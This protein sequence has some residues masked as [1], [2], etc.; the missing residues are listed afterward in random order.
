MRDMGPPDHLRP[1]GSILGIVWAGEPDVDPFMEFTAPESLL[2]ELKVR[3]MDYFLRVRGFSM[4]DA[5]IEEGDLVQVRPLRSGDSPPDG[6]I[7][8]AEVGL[9]QALGESSGRITIKRFFRD[10]TTI[11]LQPAN[12]RLRSQNYGVDD[13]AVRG[14]IVNIVRQFSP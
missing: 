13:I 12:S 3:P 6:A 4:K 7:V 14:V 11:R 5:G 1:R 8:L 10:G 2:D 9:R